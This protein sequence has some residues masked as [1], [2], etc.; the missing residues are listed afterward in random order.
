MILTSTTPTEIT[1]G[2][3]S[4]VMNVNPDTGLYQAF[5][6]QIIYDQRYVI[7]KIGC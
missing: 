3:F 4:S 7:I 2:G 1:P 6:K 5:L